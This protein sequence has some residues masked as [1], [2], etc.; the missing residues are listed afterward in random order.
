M[1]GEA[2]PQRM[3]ADTLGNAGRLV[4]LLYQK[5]RGSSIFQTPPFWRASSRWCQNRS[6]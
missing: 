2:V 6:V 3:N 5:G 1:G 4:F